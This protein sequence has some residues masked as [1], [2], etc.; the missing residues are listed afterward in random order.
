M[1]RIFLIIVFIFCSISANCQ[2]NNEQEIFLK[3]P[4]E[5]EKI[6]N[7]YVVDQKATFKGGES[8][9]FKFYK[10]NSKFKV[11]NFEVPSKSVY[12]NLYINEKGKVYDYK[13]IKSIGADYEE[14]VTRLIS[15]MPNWEPAINKKER[16]KVV[17]FDFITFE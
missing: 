7:N 5:S 12:F 16:I 13:I 9:L 6:Y 1:K 14:E 11:K 2:V 3:K 15:L 17:V 4:S 10:K 8:E